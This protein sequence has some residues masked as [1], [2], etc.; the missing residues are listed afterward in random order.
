VRQR[1]EKRNL[2]EEDR[3][4]RARKREREIES[5]RRTQREATKALLRR[6]RENEWRRHFS[7]TLVALIMHPL[8]TFFHPLW[9]H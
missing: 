1:R 5:K 9:L 6:A 3:T 4:A 8:C 2:T 7:S